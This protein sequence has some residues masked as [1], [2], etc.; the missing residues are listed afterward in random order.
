MVSGTA[1]VITEIDDALPEM[2]ERALKAC[3]VAELDAVVAECRSNALLCLRS[4][5]G[6]VIV[7]L[8]PQGDALELFIRLAVGFKHGAFSRAE[9]SITDIARELGAQTIAF[10]PQRVGWRRI[11]GDHW[12]RRGGE[13]VRAVDGQE[14]RPSA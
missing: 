7:G 3:T 4:P 13:F 9:S 1:F 12:F 6:V 8:E 2:R 5:D 11:L 14:I 10:G